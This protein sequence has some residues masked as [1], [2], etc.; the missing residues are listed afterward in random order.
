MS[1]RRRITLVVGR[2]RRGRGRARLAAHLRCSP[3]DQ[4]HSQVD[5]QLR[6]RGRECRRCAARPRERRRTTLRRAALAAA[7]GCPTRVSAGA[8]RR[9]ATPRPRS[10]AAP[11]AAA[12]P[13]GPFRPLPPAPDQVR[14]YQQVIDASGRGPRSAPPRASRCRSTRAHAAARG[15]GGT[16]VLHAPR[17]VHGLHL[18]VLAEASAAA[19]RVQL[20][21]PLTDVDSLLA[22][23]RLIL[24]LLDIG[25]IALAALLGQLVAGAARRAAQAPHAR[26]PSTSRAR[27]DLSRRIEPTGEDEIGRLAE[28]FNAM[29]DALERLDARARRLRARAAP[30][31]RR[32]LARAAHARSPA[33]ART[34][35][36]CGSSARTWT[37][38]SAGGCSAT[39][40]SRSRS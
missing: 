26:P 34:S 5:S 3:P 40:S 11:T 21:Q 8:A 32:R 10:P 27:S 20:A 23:L 14:G 35:R 15:S 1:F 2:G 38:P 25:G 6:G 16:P 18:R 31:R 12:A 22:R 17:R 28:S 33:C 19:A 37:R 39:S 9:G 13:R 30:A 24:V 4:L 29:L 36:S 7:R